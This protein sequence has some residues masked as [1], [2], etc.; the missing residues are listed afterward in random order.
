M[1]SYTK[2]SLDGL[3]IIGRMVASA[4]QLMARPL[5]V[6]EEMTPVV[7]HTRKPAAEE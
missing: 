2:E 7:R 3:A 1:N 6:V 4:G 5:E